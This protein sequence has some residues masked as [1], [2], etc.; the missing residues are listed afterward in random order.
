M[1]NLI[2]TIVRDTRSANLDGVIK[3]ALFLLNA[4]VGGTDSENG[5]TFLWI[6]VGYTDDYPGSSLEALYQAAEA[7]GLDVRQTWT[8]IKGGGDIVFVTK[9]IAEDVCPEGGTCTHP[10]GCQNCPGFQEGSQGCAWQR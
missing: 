4:G 3:K 7:A 2:T 8:G 9:T 1:T 5:E 10:H 6:N